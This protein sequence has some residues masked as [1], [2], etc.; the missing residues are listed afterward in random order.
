M[1]FQRLKNFLGPSALAFSPPIK[2]SFLYGPGMLYPDY[3]RN[4]AITYTFLRVLH[5]MN[6][7]FSLLNIGATNFRCNFTK[8]LVK[9]TKKMLISKMGVMFKHVQYWLNKEIYRYIP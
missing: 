8:V 3:T 6:A 9:K 5:M 4:H 2:K 7:R 1:A